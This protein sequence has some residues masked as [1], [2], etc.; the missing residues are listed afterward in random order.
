MPS[1]F[2]PS[3]VVSIQAPDIRAGEWFPVKVVAVEE[4]RQVEISAPQASGRELFIPA[5]YK[6][7]LEV[8]RPDGVRRMTAHVQSRRA[9]HPPILVLDWPQVDERIQ[10]RDSVRIAV[11][12]PVYVR[13]FN[14]AGKLGTRI[15][16][17]VVDLSAGG[18]QVRLPEPL[19]EGLAVELALQIPG[20]GERICGGAIV[21][22][23]IA[24]QAPDATPYSVGVKFTDITEAARRDITKFV[25]DTQIEY[26]RKGIL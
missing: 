18:V 21:R 16:G 23:S 22:A 14:A 12:F 15:N 25:F 9:N 11:S 2:W 19:W 17:T 8:I 10:R 1:P 6:V 20:F 4:D 3:Q 26:L 13:P 24:D 5:D 7:L